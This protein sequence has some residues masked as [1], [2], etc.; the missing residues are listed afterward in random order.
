MAFFLSFEILS[1]VYELLDF[2]K[3]CFPNAYMLMQDLHSDLHDG[4][5]GN[6]K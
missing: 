6:K 2:G 1:K 3:S 4:V 5:M